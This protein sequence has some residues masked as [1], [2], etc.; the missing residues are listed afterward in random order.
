M[1]RLI[2]HTRTVQSIAFPANGRFFATGGDDRTIR[3]SDAASGLNTAC[4]RGA[5]AGIR[6]VALAGDGRLLCSTDT[7]RCVRLWDPESG[8]HLAILARNQMGSFFDCAFSLNDKPIDEPSA[9]FFWQ[10][11]GQRQLIARIDRFASQLAFSSDGRLFAAGGGDS[12][13]LFDASALRWVASFK[14]RSGTSALGFSSDSRR[15]AIAGNEVSVWSIDPPIRLGSTPRQ[16]RWIQALA[17]TPDGRRLLTAGHDGLVSV[18]GT[19]TFQLEQALDFGIGNL[20]CLAIAPDG[21]TA[22]AGGERGGLV[23]WDLDAGG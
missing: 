13:D 22:V 12:A 4:L 7:G 23:R 6:N 2:G 5:K 15:L 9:V 11:T 17:F 8:V 10:A 3:I 18:W 21:L 14:S 19:E 1:Q 20:R 16:S